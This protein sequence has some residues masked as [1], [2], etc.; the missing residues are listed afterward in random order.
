[1]PL[2]DRPPKPLSRRRPKVP[3]E[4]RQLIH[5]M[6]LANGLWGTPRI[7]GELL[8]LFKYSSSLRIDKLSCCTSS[9][10]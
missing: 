6:S 8:K 1:M 3:L 10:M 2:A 5:N 9:L 4:I 7:H